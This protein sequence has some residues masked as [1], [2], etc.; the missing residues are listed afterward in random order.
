MAKKKSKDEMKCNKPEKS[1][2]AGKKKVVK[3]CE[4]GKEKIVHYGDT[5]YSDYTK[6]KDKDRRANF[7][8]RHKCSEKKSKLGASYWACRDLWS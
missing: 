2:R 5:G 1:W 8:A 7:R 4:D 6:H 3:A